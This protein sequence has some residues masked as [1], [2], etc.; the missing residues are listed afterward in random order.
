MKR[1]SLLAVGMM[2][3]FS[4][5]ANAQVKQ[6]VIGVDGFTCSLC[7]KGV[8]GQLSSLDFVKSVKTDLKA[9]T[10]TIV[11]KSNKKISFSEIRDAVTDGGFTL[12]D[13][14][15]KADGTLSGDAASGF[16]LTTGNT[17]NL[18]LKNVS[19]D[20]SNGD[21]VMVQGNVNLPS[22]VKVTTIKKL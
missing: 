22:S 14:K 8:E 18:S 19:G 2:L 13:I 12:R 6:A 3:L 17:P 7:A 20:Y 15:V 11:F 21:K 16:S 10:F 4:L 1:L 9:T 5:S